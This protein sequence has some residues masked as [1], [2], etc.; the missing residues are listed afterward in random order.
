MFISTIFI[1]LF[2]QFLYV[3][4]Y[5]FYMFISTIFI[6][7]FL[8]FLYFFLQF[9]FVSFYY[10]HTFQSRILI[11]ETSTVESKSRLPLLI[12]VFAHVLRVISTVS[13]SLTEPLVIL[14][15]DV[16]TA[17]HGTFS[18]PSMGGRLETAN[19]TEQD[20]SFCAAGEGQLKQK[21]MRCLVEMSKERDVSL[22]INKIR[23]M[24]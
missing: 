4:F 5:V 3:Y 24:E 6:C 8:R 7:L 2:L 15:V 19:S 9:L 17:I 14:C 22:L 23:Q 18:S 20:G 10:F 21:L 12:S 16:L 11:K 13:A 1:C